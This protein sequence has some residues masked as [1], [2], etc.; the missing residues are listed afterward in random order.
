[1][2]TV[3]FLEELQSIL[4]GF[5]RGSLKD[6][7]LALL[8]QL[9][10]RS[11]KQI[12]LEPNTVA[13]FK[14][15]F[16]NGPDHLQFNDDRALTHQWQ[17]VDFLFQLAGDDLAIGG[18]WPLVRS[19]AVDTSAAA[20][21]SYL[22]FAIRLKDR[23]TPYTRTELSNITREVNK[24]F[25]MPAM[26]IF[27]HGQ[28]ITLSV[29]NRRLDKRYS[30]RDVLEKVTLIKDINIAQTHRAHLEILADL[31]SDELYRVQGFTS[32]EELH[33]AWQKTLDSS[34][35]NKRF[36]QE[37]ANWYFWAVQHVQF[38]GPPEMD[39]QS[40]NEINTI[41]LITRLIF[42]WFLKEKGLVS[43][44]LFNSKKLKDWLKSLKK[45]DSTYYRAILQ[46]L[47]FATLNQEMNWPSKKVNRKFRNRSKQE[48][49]RDQN[50]GIANL[51]RYED[52]FK[53]AA[54][55]VE[56]F[57]QVPFLNGGLFECLDK[58]ENKLRI[59]GF[60]DNPRLAAIVP[61][62]LFFADEHEP[63]VDLNQIY[64]IK[65][66][67]YKVRG[68]LEIFNR[69][70]FTITENTP[71]EE[72]IALDPELLGKVFENL[73]AAYNLETQT[74]ARKQTGSFYTPREIVD[75]MVDEALVAHFETALQ[76]PT[77]AQ[78]SSL[79]KLG[80]RQDVCP[81]LREKLRRLVDYRQ[82]GNP[83][84]ERTPETETLIKA[85]NGLKVLDPAVGSGAFP[86]GMLQK[87]VLILGKLDPNNAL[88]KE[89]QLEQA[90]RPMQEDIQQAQ[91]ISYAQARKAAIEQ[92]QERLA[93][94]E[95]EFANADM[96][97]PRK[98][99]LIEN[100]IYG[101]DIQPVAVQI[102]KLRFF[103][104]L[105]VE[106]TPDD[107]KSNRGIKALPNLETQF[108]AANSLFQIDKQQSLRPDSVIEKEKELQ[109]VRHK[110]FSARTPATKKKYRNLDKELRQDISTLLKEVGL[111]A[112][113][114]DTLANWDPYNQNAK[115]DFF[116]PHWMFGIEDGFDI[117][118]GNPPYVRQEQITA[119]KPQLK[120]LYECYTGVADLYVYFFERALQL[121]KPG[122]V[123]TYICSNKYFR[124]NYGEKL[125]NLLSQKTRIQTLIDFGDAP[126]FTAIAYPSIIVT[127]QIRPNGNAIAAMNWETDRPVKEFVAVFED[128]KFDLAQTYLSK[129][130]WQL[131]SP[132]IF[133]ILA[134]LRAKGTPLKKYLG[135]KIYR[136]I[137]TGLNEAFIIDSSMRQKL[138]SEHQSSKE[139]IKPFIRG[140]NVKRWSTEDKNVWLIFTR[141]GTAINNYPAIKQHLG[142]YKKSLEARLNVIRDGD[143]WFQIPYAISYWK[144][145]EQPKII[146]PD[147]AI[148]CNFSFSLD[149]SYL[150]CTLSLIPSN[151]LYVLGVLN[152]SI[153]NFFFGQICPKV[154]GD[155]MRFKTIYVEQ[156]P[157]PPASDADKAAISAL[158]QKCLDAKGQGVAQWE[159]EIDDRVAHLYG[160]TSNDLKIIRGE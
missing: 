147:I 106:Q 109:Q 98:L 37:V 87:L 23:A 17:S 55:V 108:V 145:F 47:F 3:T 79:E 103:I 68:L 27:Q 91:K 9:G 63:D 42:V 82:S 125:R 65:Q 127:Q 46:N 144:K 122:G 18:Q 146:Y 73:L 57:N 130:G 149:T 151:E 12:D 150:D 115:A 67:S 38:P 142:K 4:H 112:A 137:V 56:K 32:F 51:W 97:Y 121:L 58:A 120:P 94:I 62:E 134:K 29:I 132:A 86:M 66:R 159:A 2:A 136:G 139:L 6:N 7:A 89:E 40:R 105:I 114:A 111:S 26:V 92:L 53:D 148:E 15:N 14:E 123:L 20:W 49:G 100:C 19:R 119:I 152:S 59:D 116:D 72:E 158:V 107:T 13:T 30:D 93:A 117:V 52:Y 69:Y 88:W 141:K 28:T 11:D 39:P 160:L 8:G 16:D 50:Y 22:F 31:A 64:G 77:V 83:F 157:I 135:E 24:L 133:N 45:D 104:S 155:F 78:A 153:T 34:E 102:A 36:F 95:A 113:I 60:S 76:S 10:Y 43:D 140:K 71:V 33:Q 96:D 156:I 143:E 61:N 80:S 35:L 118:I 70:K 75:Y 81:T 74:T 138:I 110:N 128:N 101:V 154:R 5:Q 48:D 21:Q 84:G 44:D 85:I 124:A 99:F 54:P 131:E 126:V 129:D 25:L 1:M 41:R 90:I